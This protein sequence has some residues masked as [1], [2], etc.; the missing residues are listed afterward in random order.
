MRAFF[1]RSVL[2]A[3]NYMLKLPENTR[4]LL[5][6]ILFVPLIYNASQVPC[7]YINYFEMTL[8]FVCF[9]NNSI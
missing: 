7:F 6:L 5:L 4:E 8:F 2:T 3:N 1:C 9:E